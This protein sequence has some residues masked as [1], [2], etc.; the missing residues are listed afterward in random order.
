MDHVARCSRIFKESS[1]ADGAFGFDRFW[2]AGLMPFRAGLAFRE[3]FLLQTGDEFRI[4]TMGGNN[5]A[6]APGKFQ[7][8]VHFAVIDSK[9]ILV[10]EKN[11]EGSR[12]IGNDLA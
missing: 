3:Q 9:E 7:G 2:P 8:L 4:F 11:F 10:G 1:E 5:D 12:A 6:E